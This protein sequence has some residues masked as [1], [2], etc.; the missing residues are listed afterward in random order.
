[1]AD[2]IAPAAQAKAPLAATAVAKSAN[3]PQVGNYRNPEATGIDDNVGTVADEPILVAA[4]A[5]RVLALCRIRD[6]LWS[7]SAGFQDVTVT[8]A[9]QAC[10]S[11]SEVHGDASFGTQGPQRQAYK[12]LSF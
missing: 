12:V 7:S 6:A 8:E 3:R 9:L 2:E 10:D 5:N 1:M 11:V 4:R